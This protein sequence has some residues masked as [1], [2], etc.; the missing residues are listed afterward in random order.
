M[1]RSS[2]LFTKRNPKSVVHLSGFPG[3][4]PVRGMSS[5][6]PKKK[7]WK[8]RPLSTHSTSR[9]SEDL[10]YYGNKKQTAVSLQALMETGLGNR[11]D[12]S[13][14]SPDE[15]N[16]SGA[17]ERVKIQIACFLH[18]ELPIRLAHRAV[19][20]ENTKEFADNRHVN[21][22]IS[23][24][25]TSFKALR[26]CPA[27]TDAAKEEHFASICADMY[28]R[29]SHTLI[30]MAM[31]AHELRNK[32]GKSISEFATAR[33]I[34]QSLD[35]FYKSRIGIRILIGQYLALRG[36]RG[37]DSDPTMIGL[38]SQKCSV[39]DIAEKAIRD[40]RY[41]CDRVH[42]DSPEVHILGRTDQT[43]PYIPSHLEYM[44][45]EL[46]KNSLRATVETHGVD[47]MPRI[48]V[49]IADSEDNEDCVIKI[50]DEGGGIPRSNISK[51]WS[52]LFTTADPAIL[53]S[54]LAEDSGPDF[55]TSSPLAGLGYGIPISRAYARYFGGDLVIMSMEGYGTDSY[56]YVPKLNDKQLQSRDFLS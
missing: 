55:A 26:A 50:S 10:A 25:K 12:G 9:A 46:L 53:E 2:L 23:W 34:Q 21:N 36:N 43:F 54:I 41:M 8:F 15:V 18:R 16:F 5:V 47:N 3:I 48:K 11:L 13:D 31:A 37:P 38:I 24:Y 1:S 51:V 6:P 27:P 17:S 45:L 7:T 20:L 39:K 49:V 44:L 22:V 4:I 52:Y 56:I 29:H 42:G 32:L 30:T 14:T 28:D 40:A 35:D 19:D 33:A